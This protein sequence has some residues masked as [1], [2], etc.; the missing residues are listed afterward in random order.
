M[1]RD[2]QLKN[3]VKVSYVY[4]F[5]TQLNM[6]SAIWVLY[7]A[8]RGMS[9]IEI[10]LLESV[11]HLTGVLFELPTGVIADV[12]GKRFTVI[13]GR[14]ISIVSCVLMITADGFWGFAI[15]FSLSA[16]ALN[17]HSGAA[18]ALVYDSLKIVGEEDKYKV[19]WG[20]LAFAMSIAQGAAVL[21][22]GILADVKFL[23]VYIVGTAIQIAA[24][25]VSWQ[26]CEPPVPK[27]Q[28]EQNKQAGGVL[29]SQFTTSMR[30]LMERKTVLYVMLF[31]A[32]AGSLQTTVFFYSQKYFSDMSYSKTVIAM[33]CALGSLM[34]GVSS[35]YA[36]KL[37]KTMQLRGT[38]IS[39]ACINIFSLAGLAFVQRLS[40]V[41]FL[42]IA[43]SGGVGF[44]LF[45]AYINKGI[46]SEYRA[47]ILSCDSLLF[48]LFMIGIFPLVG[49]I[50]EEMSFSVTFG[51]M[52]LLYMPVMAFL[53]T[54]LKKHT[55]KEFIEEIKNDRISCE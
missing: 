55:H 42:L 31:S 48:S 30:V 23:Y 52:A 35:K 13:A 8:F 47:T 45:S 9:L 10:G 11:Y 21:L 1:N 43:V 20:N 2:D 33:I 27:E 14:I 17:L 12:Y 50:A 5:L 32:L 36:Y 28:K 16:A 38:L 19:I 3:N 54:K 26:F 15:A 6:S 39:I 49:W 46:P 24:L 44:T 53:A 37:E 25:A 4:N 29:V 40:I 18:E 22:G 7:L 41:F 34:E 51:M